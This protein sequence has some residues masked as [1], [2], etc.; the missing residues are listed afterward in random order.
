M[1]KIKPMSNDQYSDWEH[2]LNYETVYVNWEYALQLA[3]NIDD[4]GNRIR[5]KAA[6]NILAE[7][8]S[9]AYR[10]ALPQFP[11]SNNTLAIIIDHPIVHFCPSISGLSG[12]FIDKYDEENH[13]VSIRYEKSNLYDYTNINARLD[14]WDFFGGMVSV[15]KEVF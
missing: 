3:E 14:G 15:N 12:V 11:G 1:L 5:S 2:S 7:Y 8:G 9:I 13:G 10:C 6:I 4:S